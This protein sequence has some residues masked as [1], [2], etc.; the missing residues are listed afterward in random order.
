MVAGHQIGQVA[1]IEAPVAMAKRPAKYPEDE[2]LIT[3]RIERRATVYCNAT[4]RMIQN[5]L[6]GTPVIDFVGGTEESGNAQNGYTFVG[7]RVPDL[8][9]ALPKI[10]SVIEPVASTATLTL[11][12]LRQTID[13]LNAV[14]GQE[15]DLR[16]ALMKL[17]ATADNVSALTAPDGSM[18]HTLTN[19]QELTTRLKADD[20]PLMATLNNLQKTT[21]DINRDGRVEKMLANFEQ[22]G[23][24]ADNAAK[25]AS[26]LLTG[27]TPSVNQTAANLAQMS[28]TLKRQ[29]WRI[30]WPATKKYDAP[31]G[32]GM[33]VPVAAT[34]GVRP[35]KPVARERRARAAGSDEPR[36]VRSGP[37][38]TD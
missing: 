30:I 27:L 6:L 15:G 25:Q 17:R 13:T 5:G 38:L 35:S 23:A 36:E 21:G 9:S 2:V 28:D 19:L 12:E 16:A 14:F 33:E 4:P 7:E 3:V 29:P 31:P 20:G 10:L 22:A 8:N 24:R 11:R 1:A 18:G 37:L 34:T 32:S 26:A